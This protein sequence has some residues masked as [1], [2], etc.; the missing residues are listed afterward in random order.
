[1]PIDLAQVARD[2]L[3]LVRFELRDSRVDA[4]V[5]VDGQPARVLADAVQ[6]QQ[7]CVNLYKNACEACAGR[8]RGGRLEIELRQEA[9]RV[10]LEVHD[11]GPGL[12]PEVRERLF[13]P[14]TSTK[15]EGMGLGLAICRSI[16]EAHGG[17]LA[18]APARLGGASF[19]LELPPIQ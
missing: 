18:A 4:T 7:V 17:R 11:D 16:V 2:A 5:R 15:P 19:R 14:Y 13:E 3:Q 10:V 8:P 6:L 1:M 12:A 9:G